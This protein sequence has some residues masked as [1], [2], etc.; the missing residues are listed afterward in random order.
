LIE[1]RY[2]MDEEAALK[3]W[4]FIGW[5]LILAALYINL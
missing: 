1:E 2:Q 4:T 5:V 3:F